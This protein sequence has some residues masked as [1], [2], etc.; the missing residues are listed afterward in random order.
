[1]DLIFYILFF[2]MILYTI[3]LI[4]FI[5]GN[6]IPVNINYSNSIPSVSIIV[7]IKNGEASLIKLIENL[8]L[9]DYSGNMEFILIDDQSTDL[10]A[11]LIHN[12]T[13]KDDRF[14]YISSKKGDSCLN[15]KKRALDAGINFANNEWLLFTDVDCTIP[16]TWVKGM[17]KY[18]TKKTDYVI[19]YSEVLSNNNW[20]TKFQ[21]LDFLMLMIS[22]RGTT[23]IGF[24]WA[25]SGQN[26][27]YK[28]SFFKT[29]GGFSKIANQLQGDD[30]LFLQIYLKNISKNVEFADDKE[31]RVNARQENNII[32]FLKQ[33]VRWSGDAK[34]MWKFNKIFFTFIIVTF[35]LPLMLITSFL[36]SIFLEP[37]FITIFI[38]FLF[39]H[40][41]IEFLLYFVGSKK[42]SKPIELFSFYLWFLIHIP[43][44]IVMGLGSFFAYRIQW[45]K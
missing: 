33:R 45:R 25:C 27:A 39:I 30:S 1:M 35:L 13:K 37:Y 40:F 9:Q 26:Q 21:S 15:H 29:I 3:M 41:I 36:Y 23:N 24:P 38:R 31:C 19:G 32:S 11:K 4:W 42:L 14:K 2:L 18:F 12:I 16:I 43:Y 6:L 8:R 10:T 28:K 44:V 7:A 20:I 22:A 34:I 5:I 17:A